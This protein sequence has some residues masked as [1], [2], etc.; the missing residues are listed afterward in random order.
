MQPIFSSVSTT[1]VIAGSLGVI[2]LVAAIVKTIAYRRHAIR[3][4][5]QAEE[6]TNGGTE[7]SPIQ[8]SDPFADKPAPPPADPEPAPP[9]KKRSIYRWE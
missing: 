6:A 8:L 1:S 2:F 4:K 7:E 3:K 9:P 5:N